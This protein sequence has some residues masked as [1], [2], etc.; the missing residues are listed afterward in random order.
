M[1][2]ETERLYLR[3]LTESDHAAL[4]SVLGNRDIMRFYP[5]IF[6]A[7]RVSWW[8]RR[9]M[10]RYRIF[11]YGLW[12]VCLKETGELIGD[13]GLTISEPISKGRVTQVKPPLLSCLSRT[14]ST[15]CSAN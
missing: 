3:E 2:L 9:N 15:P 10:E 4:S 11:G 6:D 8:I 12:S 14:Q 5:Y 13:C 7:A 1:I